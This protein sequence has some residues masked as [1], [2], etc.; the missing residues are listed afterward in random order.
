MSS[1]LRVYIGW[2]EAEK[3]AFPACV[4]SLR[5]NSSV[6]IEVI[7]IWSEYLRIKG[8]YSREVNIRD[9]QMYDR[10]DGKPFSTQFSFA[11]FGVIPL[12]MERCGGEEWV[13]FIDPDMMFRADVADLFALADD[14]K[15][16]M[17]VKHDHK[18]TEETKILG[19][20]QT[21]YYRKNWSSMMLIKPN[22]CNLPARCLNEWTGSDLHALRFVQDNEIGSI[23]EEWNWLEGWSPEEI[24]PKLLHYT[25]GTPDM[26]GHENA[27][28][29]DEWWSYA[30]L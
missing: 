9:G 30:K 21:N 17:C 11:R 12:E 4:K 24:E 13:L 22:R 18:P 14:T 20:L 2:D 26:P 28:Y 1:P 6:P 23:P 27:R 19:Q 15:S 25:R 3:L 10:M 16:L 5:K 7:P 8:L 29:A